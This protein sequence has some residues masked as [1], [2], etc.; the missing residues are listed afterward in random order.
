MKLVHERYAARVMHMLGMN[1]GRAVVF[2]A[3]RS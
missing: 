1:S 2:M 3:C